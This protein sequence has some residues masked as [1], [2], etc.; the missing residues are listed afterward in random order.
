[1][2]KVPK[3]CTRC[4][5]KQQKILVSC[6]KDNP[7]L[8]LFLRYQLES[9]YL[10]IMTLIDP[11]R[12]RTLPSFRQTAPSS[13]FP[14]FPLK[15]ASYIL[16]ASSRVDTFPSNCASSRSLGLAEDWPR[17]IAH[18]AQSSPVSNLDGRFLRE[19]SPPGAASQSYTRP[20]AG[21]STC[22]PADATPCAPRIVATGQTASASRVASVRR[23]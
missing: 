11:L 9:I 1:M 4:M 17:L 2:H 10:I 14:V 8:S 19:V 12:R 18:L 22:S 15:S 23:P 20:N 7:A 21:G 16:I 5:I 6:A 3:R 13:V